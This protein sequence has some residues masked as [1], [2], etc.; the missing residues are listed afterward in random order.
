VWTFTA[1]STAS[2]LGAFVAAFFTV[3]TLVDAA[4]TRR[5]AWLLGT[6][7]GEAAFLV[8]VRLD[9]PLAPNLGA[10]LRYGLLVVPVLPAVPP[11]LAHL[12]VALA[13]RLRRRQ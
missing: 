13:R 3:P 4:W 1:A 11:L 9:G 5:R 7:A 2:A 6:L 10:L 8:F 12:G